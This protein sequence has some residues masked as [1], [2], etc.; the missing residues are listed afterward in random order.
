MD[1]LTFANLIFTHHGNMMLLSCQIVFG[2]EFHH[3]HVNN[4]TGGSIFAKIFK[5]S[6]PIPAKFLISNLETSLVN[7]ESGSFLELKDGVELEIYDS[8]IQ[9]ITSYSKGSVISINGKGTTVRIYNSQINNNTAEQGGVFNI[10]SNSVIQL[11]NTSVSY[12]FAIQG[13]VISTSAG[14][15]FEFYESRILNNYA[16]SIP[17]GLIFDTT[18]VSQLNNCLI[19]ENI[20]MTKSDFLK[21]I[22]INCALL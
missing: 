20:A 4:V 18:N 3:L 22:N 16:I 2:V 13:G 6:S 9:T 12:N 1:H 11:Y 10:N 5:A 8:I 15:H 19:R 17:V 14:G 21:E 7:S